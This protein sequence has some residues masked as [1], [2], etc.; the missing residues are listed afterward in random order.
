MLKEKH[1]VF[2]MLF[3][4]ADLVSV[5]LAWC[6]AY[7]LRFESGFFA[8]DKGKP[9]FEEYLSVL[10]FII[11]IW[12]FTFRISGLYRPK[13][14]VRENRERWQLLSAN[15]I[16]CLILVNFVYLFREKTVP[17][18]RAV[19]LTFF[20]FSLTFTLIERSFFRYLL[21]DIRRK[22]YNLRYMLI[23]GG[24]RVA[25]DLVSRIRNRRELGVQLLGCLTLEGIDQDGPDGLPVVGSY[26]ELKRLISCIAI[27]QVVIALPLVDSHLLPT[28]ME[29][30]DDSTVDVKIVP[31][32]YQFISIGGTIEEFEGLPVIGLQ[33]SP[34]EGLNLFLK[35]ILD[36]L[37][38]LPVFIVLLPLFALIACLVKL[39]SRGPI[40]YSQERVSIDGTSFQIIKFRSM[41]IDAE[42][43]G[44]GWTVPDDNRV[45]FIG[46]I[47]RCLSLDELPQLINVIKGDMSIVGPR[48][49]R[50]VY[51]KEFRK[52][53]PRYILRH[54]VPAGITGWAQINGWRGDTA[55]DRRIEFDLYYIENWSLLFDLKIL[56]LTPF[57]GFYNR[58]AY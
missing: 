18:S 2:E 47:I 46:K 17:F 48:P 12:T 34:I 9:R 26:Y 56:F 39:S 1:R 35:R 51:I 6:A 7:W 22:G 13:R 54:K 42:K 15:A 8:L 27:D 58:N 21:K 3:I 11:P 31:D 45:T 33:G 43:V 53:I 28:L 19:F 41:R 44:P 30:L 38:A 40:F 49:E 24:G 5:S 4:F 37:I 25:K 14:G 52:R 10:I 36:L 20:I 16:S 32:L 23:V 29:Q 55:I 50:P 57:K